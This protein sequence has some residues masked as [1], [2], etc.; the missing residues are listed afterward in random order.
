MEADLGTGNDRISGA[1][2]LL[3]AR[4]RRRRR[5]AVVASDLASQAEQLGASLVVHRFELVDPTQKIAAC[6]GFGAMEPRW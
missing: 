3:R 5:R 4:P 2:C 1:A 6:L